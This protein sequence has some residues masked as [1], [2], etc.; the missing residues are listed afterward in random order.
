MLPFG[1]EKRRTDNGLGSL[2]SVNSSVLFTLLWCAVSVIAAVFGIWHCR[3]TAFSDSLICNELECTLKVG[4]GRDLNY[5]I[6]RSDL[7]HVEVVRVDD[8]NRVQSWY[9]LSP[10]ETSMLGHNVEL[11]FMYTTD[12]SNR[13]QIQKTVL[14]SHADMG[15]IRARNAYAQVSGYIEK[16]RD[17]V[18]IICKSRLSITGVMSIAIGS[19]SA[20]MSCLAGQWSDP[21][22]RR[23]KKRY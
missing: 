3:A 5:A 19:I 1:N 4:D 15:L 14:L 2:G 12:P 7:T 17:N 6:H 11:K 16:K 21:V 13:Y 9:Q 8:H 22:P 10:R 23:L 18:Q 20:L